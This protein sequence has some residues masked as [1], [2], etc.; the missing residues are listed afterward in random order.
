MEG[1]DESLPRA[2]YRIEQVRALDRLAIE[3]CGIAGYTL[4]TRAAAA[5]LDVLRAEWPRA[6][7]VLVCCGAGNNAGDGYVLARL[8][9]Q[10]GLR[11]AVLAVVPRDALRG[12]AAQA[13]RD[14]TAAGVP[15]APFD[16]ASGQVE[17][18]G[19]DV[20]VDALLGT[21]ATRALDGDYAR[22]VAL[23]NDSGVPVLALD[24]PSGLHG[25][26][27]LTLGAAVRAA[28][29]VTFVGLKT[30]LF[31]GVARE[32]CGRI[33]LADLGV[34]ASARRTQPPALERLVPADLRAALPRRSRTAHK[35]DHGRA[36]LVG[37]APGM[38]GAIRLAAE[39]ALRAGA[40]LVYVAAHPQSVAIVAAGRPEVM[41]HAVAGASD[42]EP[43]LERADAVVI[44]PGLG[45]DEW[46][47]AL[48]HR[49]LAA[50]VPLV[51]DA[52]GL[53]LLAAAPVK[54][55]HWILTPHPGE[56]ARLLGRTA[57]DVQLDRLGA[58][59]TL[60]ERYGGVAVLKGACSLVAVD[61]EHVHVCDRGN[62]GMAAAGMGDVLSGVIG[63]LLVQHQELGRAARAGVLLHALAGDSAA[64]AGERGLAAGDLLPEI[65]RWA[66]PS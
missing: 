25:D 30:G 51:V 4:M 7:H 52:D 5:A 40:G 17:A 58:V 23:I 55:A 6:H 35:G 16:A 54:R 61:T 28:V 43:L 26:T 64:A 46:A 29:T 53:N 38:S 14:C 12:D 50:P 42:L 19:P 9:A 56:A 59:R 45:Q 33:E 49:V 1:P 2:V 65:R 62:P 41:C 3:Q 10:A 8:A 37:G 63:G 60:V 24:L 32:Y 20:I 57:A 18:F 66:N 48:L 13:E 34:P 11:A 21:G 39:A 44:G 31:L 27:G 36:L 47:S 22:A 15:I